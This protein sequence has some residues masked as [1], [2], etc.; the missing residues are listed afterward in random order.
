MESTNRVELT[1]KAL[2]WADALQAIDHEAVVVLRGWWC[3]G[4]GEYFPNALLDKDD[5]C[6]D[7]AAEAV[8]AAELDSAEEQA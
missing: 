1:G 7:C 4:C 8:T 3:T 5:R 6:P 2:P